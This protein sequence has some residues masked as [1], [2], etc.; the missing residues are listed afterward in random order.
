V[1]REPS[2]RPTVVRVVALEI[3]CVVILWWIGRVFG[4]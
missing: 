4:A 1:S 3:L 2:F